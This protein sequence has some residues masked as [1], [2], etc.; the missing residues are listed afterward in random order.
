MS[1]ATLVVL[2][3]SVTCDLTRFSGH[4]DNF[5][6]IAW[7]SFHFHVFPVIF[8]AT[9]LNDLVFTR[10]CF[11]SRGF[12]RRFGRAGKSIGHRMDILSRRVYQGCVCHVL[13]FQSCCIASVARLFGSGFHVILG[14]LVTQPGGKHSNFVVHLNMNGQVWQILLEK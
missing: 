4:G 8:H 13:H 1:S 12:S 6:F 7:N 2:R 10:G 14:K 5:G 3:R 11:S 9:N